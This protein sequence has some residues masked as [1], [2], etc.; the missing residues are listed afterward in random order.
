[1]TGDVRMDIPRAAWGK[2]EKACVDDALRW[3][4]SHQSDDGRWESEGWG[5]WCNGKRVDGSRLQGRGLPQYDVGVTGL[6]LLAFLGAG[7]TER[8][9]GPFAKAIGRGLRYLENEQ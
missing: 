2:E 5:N 1:G 8:S 4:A 7:Y 9:G 3:L 6:A